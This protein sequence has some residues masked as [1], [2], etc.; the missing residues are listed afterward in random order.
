[1]GARFCLARARA[2]FRLGSSVKVS[3]L[4]PKDDMPYDMNDSSCVLH[5][6]YMQFDALFTGD[7]GS[8]PEGL[9]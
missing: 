8:G 5:I 4:W 2:S 9:L 1:M 3:F 6:E 7:I